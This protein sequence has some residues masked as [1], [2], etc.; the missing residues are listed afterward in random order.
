MTRHFSKR[1]IELPKVKAE[2]LFLHI[3]EQFFLSDAHVG[4]T[5]MMLVWQILYFNENFWPFKPLNG[6]K[7]QSI[8]FV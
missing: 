4:R 6:Y 1:K 5:K 7:Y 3:T 8:K 2:F